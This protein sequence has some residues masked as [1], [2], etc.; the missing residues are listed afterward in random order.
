M[1]NKLQ[2]YLPIGMDTRKMIKKVLVIYIVPIIYSMQ[3]IIAFCNARID[4]IKISKRM[5]GVVPMEEFPQLVGNSFFVF[6]FAIIGM[7]A[8]IWPMY[9]YHFQGSKSIYIMKRIPDPKELRRRILTIPLVSAI[10]C[11]ITGILLW[12]LYYGI[13]IIFSPNGS[14]I[15]N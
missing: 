8:I 11:L 12:G 13:Y 3:Y 14:I 15:I 2:E 5:G 4:Q 6:P 9:A 1:K 7:L 10:G